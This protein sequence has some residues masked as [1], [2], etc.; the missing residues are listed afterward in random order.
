MPERPVEQQEAASRFYASLGFD[1]SYFAAIWHTYQVGRLLMADLD[2]I[3]MA[4]GLSMADV[5]LIGVVRQ[6]HSGHLRATDL[7]QTLQVSNAVLSTRL[8]K[9]E[10]KGLVTREPDPADRRAFQVRLTAAGAETL[11]LAITAV[12]RQSNFVKSYGRLTPAD[13]WNS[14]G[15][16]ACSIPNSTA[17]SCPRF[18][19]VL[20]GLNISPFGLRSARL[21]WRAKVAPDHG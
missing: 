18:A 1:V 15:S 5:H 10:A 4:Q 21:S 12:D 7:A 11:D 20:R 14:Q 19:A 17:I 16:W 9:L 3:C 2:R 6:H 13:R 8:A